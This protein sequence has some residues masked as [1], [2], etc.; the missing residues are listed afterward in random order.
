MQ[1][2]FDTNG[3][4]DKSSGGKMIYNE[5]I[6]REPPEGSSFTPL[7]DI[8]DL[9]QSKIIS[10]KEINPDGKSLVYGVNLLIQQISP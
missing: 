9:Y 6:K 4:P 2:D 5:E 1:F 8:Y 7:G 10:E 3:R